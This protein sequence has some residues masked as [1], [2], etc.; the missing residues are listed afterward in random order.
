[1]TARTVALTVLFLSCTAC[2]RGDPP[3][4]VLEWGSNGNGVGQFGGSHGVEVDADGNV[5]IA[6]TGNN[7]IQ[8]FTSDGVFLMMWGTFGADP[9]NSIIHMGS[10]SAR[11][12][13]FTLRK[14]E[15]IAFRNSRVTE[16]L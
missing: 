7:R 6:D 8:K 13:T 2:V 10:A 12:V 5:Y 14:P 15:T 11:W 16:H 1:M 3:E 9:V 4:F